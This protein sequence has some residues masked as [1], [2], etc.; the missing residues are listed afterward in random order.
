[1]KTPRLIRAA[2]LVAAAATSFALLQSVA[3]LAEPPPTGAPQIAQAAKLAL[4]H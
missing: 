2:A 1:M 3:R 4:P